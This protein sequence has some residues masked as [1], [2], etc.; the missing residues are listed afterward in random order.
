MSMSDDYSIRLAGAQDLALLPHIEREAAR[1]FEPY[2]LAEIMGTVVSGA[3]DFAA[4][5]AEGR[6]WV[7]ADA[8]NVPVGFA[9]AGVMGDNAHLDELDVLPEHGRRGLGMALVRA[10]HEW[11]ARSGFPA[12]TLTTLDRIPWNRPFYERLGYRVV[13]PADLSEPLRRLLAEEIARGLPGEGRV[14]MYCPLPPA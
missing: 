4:A 6:L 1:L 3:E 9:L 12:I 13:A 10:V 14:A 2:G 8:Q 7:A 11:A 5:H